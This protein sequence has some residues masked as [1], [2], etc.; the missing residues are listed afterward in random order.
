MR[1]LIVPN[2]DAMIGAY[3]VCP[4]EIL[5][6]AYLAKVGSYMELG[7]VITKILNVKITNDEIIIEME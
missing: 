5:Q 3:T 7:G 4:K 2:K 1:K 6:D